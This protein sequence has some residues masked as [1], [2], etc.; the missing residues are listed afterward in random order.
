ME[1]VFP[2]HSV[3][4]IQTTPIGMPRGLSS[5]SDQADSTDHL[6]PG[7]LILEQLFRT[8]ASV[9][10]WDGGARGAFVT[11]TK[12][13]AVAPQGEEKVSRWVAGAAMKSLGGSVGC[14]HT[15]DPPQ[16][17]G[18]V[19]NFASWLHIVL[20]CVLGPLWTLT[21]KAMCFFL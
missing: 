10:A 4:G 17:V 6:T 16:A 21:S 11:E 14:E 2:T 15:E 7:F 18:K 19:T 12:V 20:A 9:V 3:H 13:E 8:V 1:M 5:L